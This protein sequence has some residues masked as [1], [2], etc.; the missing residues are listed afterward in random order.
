MYSP[1]IVSKTVSKYAV[2]NLL[3]YVILIVNKKYKFEK[4]KIS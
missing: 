1:V 2:V 4:K 3:K